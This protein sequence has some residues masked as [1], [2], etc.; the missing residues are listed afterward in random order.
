MEDQTIRSA[1]R[2]FRLMEIMAQ[3]GALGVTELSAR[4]GLNKATVYRQL[5][6]LIA[7]G[8]A[9][10]EESGKYRLTLKLLAVAGQ[11]LE[12]SDLRTVVQPYLRRLAEQTGET[13]HLVQREDNAIVYIDKVEPTVNSIRMVSRIGMRQPLTCTAVGKALLAELRDDEIRQI[14]SQ[15]PSEALT[16]NTLV[17]W[18]RFFAALA[19][20]RADG[21]ATDDEE[22]ELGVRCVAVALPDYTGR[23]THAVSVSAPVQRMPDRRVPEIAA[24]L[25]NMRR[26]VAADCG[27]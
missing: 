22:N 5:T 15:R 19:R 3:A 26:A 17:Q 10:Q 8:Y 25:L 2:M 16:P 4:S 20:I 13:V 1:Q 21:Y 6:T 14:W 12:Q 9:R 18:P 27:R 24:Q 11:L 23:C 7:M